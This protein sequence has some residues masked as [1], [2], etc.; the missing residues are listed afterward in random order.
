M[1]ASIFAAII[2]S[3]YRVVTEL[4]TGSAFDGLMYGTHVVKGSAQGAAS[5]FLSSSHYGVPSLK[6]TTHHTE[7][8][9]PRDEEM[10]DDLTLDHNSSS[11]EIGPAT[12]DRTITQTT[13]WSLHV[14]N[15][16]EYPDSLPNGC[17]SGGRIGLR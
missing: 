7:H 17:T 16:V 8:R 6:P 1:N 2:P 9:D 12:Y 4:H 5:D 13:T 3:L 15:D 10:T 11:E 14:I